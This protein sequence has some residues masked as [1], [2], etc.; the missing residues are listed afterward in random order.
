MSPREGGFLRQ[1]GNHSV[2]NLAVQ[3]YGREEIE[4]QWFTPDK[5]CT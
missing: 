2:H 4:Y 1:N 3:F 5:Q